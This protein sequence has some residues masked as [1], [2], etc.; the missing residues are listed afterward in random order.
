M[1]FRIEKQE[2]YQANTL[3]FF[4]KWFRLWPHSLFENRVV[5]SIWQSEI[6]CFHLSSVMQNGNTLDGHIPLIIKHIPTLYYIGSSFLY[7]LQRCTSNVSSTWFPNNMM[8]L[9]FISDTTSATSKAGAAYPSGAPELSSGFSYGSSC[10]I[11]NLLCSI[12]KTLVVILSFFS[13]WTLH[14]LSFFDLRLL[15]PPWL[16]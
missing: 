2:L 15:M 5:V 6:S 1:Y 14:S 8:F 4:K 12:L 16:F 10:L 3:L 13:I 9:S 7:N 11:F